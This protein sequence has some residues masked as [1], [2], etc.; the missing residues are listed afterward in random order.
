MNPFFKGVIVTVIHVCLVGTLGGK[1][2]YDRATLPRVW[3]KAAP[4][5]PNLPIRG[6]Y[7][8]LQVFVEPHGIDQAQTGSQWR[9]SRSVVLRVEN[10]HL[11]AEAKPEKTVSYRSSDLHLRSVQLGEKNSAVLNK[12]VAFFIPEHVPDPSRRLPGEQL[13]VEVTVPKKGPPR[14]IRLG[15]KKENGPVVPL[16]LK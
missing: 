16:D 2:L 13:W 15:V 4:F 7:V 3:V 10:E 11:L 5:D 6:R 8:S 14:P 1:L 12:P 9:G